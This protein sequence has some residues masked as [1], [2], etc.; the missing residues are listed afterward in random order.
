[1]IAE[2]TEKITRKRVASLKPSPENGCLYDQNDADIYEFAK[3]LEAEGLLEPLVVTLDNYIVS[4]HRRHAAL[5]LLKRVLVNCRVLA[6][7]RSDI[8]KDEY[9]ALLRR[10]NRQREKSA[11]EKVREE[12]VDVDPDDAYDQLRLS[13]FKS[14]DAALYNGVETVQVE[15]AMRRYEFSED[16]AD[17]IK[18]VL[19]VLEERR[20][21]WP[22]SVR[23]MHYPLLNFNFI[24]GYYWP[25]KD[26]PDHGTRRTLYYRNDDGSYD[27]TSD[28]VTRLRLAETVPW[29]AFADPTRPVT[30]FNPFA[31]VREFVNQ[32]IG[33]L[34]TG[35]WRNLLQSQPNH[36]ECLVEKNTV[37]HM[38][39]Q[40][41]SKY[42]VPTR[43]ARGLN[44]IDS[45]HDVA[46]AFQDSGKQRLILIVLSDYDPEGEMIPH[47]AGR[48]LRDDFGIYNLDIIKAGVTRKQIEAHALP[49][50]NFAK[51]TSSN[52][53]RYVGRNAD[54][55]AGTF[56]WKDGDDAPVWE[57]EALDPP[58]MLADLERVI[59]AVLDIDLFN[60]ELATEREEAQYLEAARRTARERLRGLAE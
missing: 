19:Q 12:L 16:K 31:N 49:P 30:E 32:E 58:V 27:A 6:I 7:R 9:T 2:R 33:G 53:D 51:E 45:F 43:S 37:Y 41:T 46:E 34:F 54:W 23:G 35:Y 4:G 15:G 39:L 8:D 17:H 18:H 28:L 11:A 56:G 59:K 55:L 47:D 38:A 5:S 26:K 29:E 14:I 40:V 60:R 36:F 44:S 57:L 22:L 10:H 13:R 20:D 3:R 48:R 24:R 21:Y 25:R 42:Q 52:Y 50:M 1:M